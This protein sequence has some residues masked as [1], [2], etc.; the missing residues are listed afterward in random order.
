MGG[1]CACT[2]ASTPN[3]HTALRPQGY[4]LAAVLACGPG[5]TLGIRSASDLWGIHR[6]ARER[7]EV[8]APHAGGR[9]I[10]TVDA[11]RMVLDARDRTIHDGIPVTTVART[12]LDLAPRLSAKRLDRALHRAEELRRFDLSAF[13]DVVR[14]GAR[15]R[16][17]RELKAALQRLRP[18]PHF[19]RS[20]LERMALR[21]I[22]AH[23]LP[24]PTV[25]TWLHTHEVDLHWPNAGVVA[26][27]DGYAF[28]KTRQAFEADRHRD[29]TLTALGYRVLR[30]TWY[31][32]EDEP[33]WVASTLRRVLAYSDPR[34]P[35]WA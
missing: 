7:H 9:R 31:Q 13:D 8:I 27:L 19:T 28:H 1:S 23:R 25:N 11:H 22:R 26:E 33:G 29:A 14:R 35:P 5:S 20:E 3:G 32:L 2:A 6:S 10:A 4:A 24:L 18:E 15:H 16:G 17:T 30:F 34:R 21:V 12:C